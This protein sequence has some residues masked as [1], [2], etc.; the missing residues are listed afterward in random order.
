LTQESD[1][2]HLRL[3]RAGG[4]RP[5]ERRAANYL[6]K[7][8]N[9]FNFDQSTRPRKLWDADGGTHRRLFKFQDFIAGSAEDAD[10]CL[11]VH[12]VDIQ[13]NDVLE[14]RAHCAEPLSDILKGLCD[15]LA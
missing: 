4:E 1:H 12:Q 7:D 8:G 11:N 6:L 10:V 13:P 5:S 14:T 3:L 15:L 2:R 9:G